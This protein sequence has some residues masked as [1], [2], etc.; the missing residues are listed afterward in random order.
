MELLQA[1]PAAQSPSTWETIKGNLSDG[2][3]WLGRNVKALGNAI[4][5]GV[6]K[7]I[8]YIKPFFQTIGKYLAEGYDKVRELL[9]QNKEVSVAV[10]GALLIGG[11]LAVFANKMCPCGNESK[12]DA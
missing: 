6:M 10:A 2:A 4:G 12:A 8:E 9:T 7:V 11:L 5:N 3:N 1:T